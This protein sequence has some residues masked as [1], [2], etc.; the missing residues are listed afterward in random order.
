MAPRQNARRKGRTAKTGDKPGAA[1]TK[2]RKRN[3]KEKKTGNQ[4]KRKY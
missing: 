4:K 1:G 2:T 3:L